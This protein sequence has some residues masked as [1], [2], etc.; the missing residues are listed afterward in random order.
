MALPAAYPAEPSARDRFILARRWQRPARDPWQHQGVLVERE[1]EARGQGITSA[2]VFLTGRECP[3]RCVMCDLWQYTLEH[4]TPPGA[5]AAQVRD[6]VASLRG[7]S[8]TAWPAQI[9]LYNAGSFF[10]PRA[11]P[12][13]D[14]PAIVDRLDGFARLVVESH[15]ALI[16]R[17]LD[18]LLELLDARAASGAP[19][20]DLEV[21]MGLET[22]HAAALEQL[23]KRMT[24]RQYVDAAARLAARGAGLRA[25]VLIAPPFVPV[26]ERMFWLAHAVD[27]AFDAGAS[28]VSLI[29][30]RAGNGA[31]DQ[32]ARQGA[33]RPPDL[34][35]VE[36]AFDAIV[37]RGRG[38]VLLDPWDLDR[39][40]TCA[41]CAPARRQ[42]VAAMNLGGQVLER[43]RC[44][45]CARRAS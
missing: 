42:R 19:R 6:A 26:A 32:L 29:P 44:D 22:T 39:L 20:V 10:D 9:K 5:V 45:A 4:D 34:E 24:V 36:D 43:V 35:E 38:R 30:V 16:G 21:A 8:E 3:W 1:P 31:M 7:R 25:F 12:D 14:Y 27:T 13:A 41:V 11:V 17:R 28:I 37:A 23:N 40:L 18:R 15:P 33:W 2:T